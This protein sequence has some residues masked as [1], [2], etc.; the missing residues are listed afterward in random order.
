MT[1]E[2]QPP[3]GHSRAASLRT[4][5]ILGDRYL[6]AGLIGEGGMGQIYQARDRRLARDVAI[7]VLFASSKDDP[8]L[9]RRLEQE[10]RVAGSLNHPNV[11]TV[12][13]VGTHEGTPYVVSELL[14]GTTLR[15]KLTAGL[16]TRTALDFAIQIAR[17][18]A[19]AHDKGI[20]HR[21]VKPE[22]VFVTRDGRVKILDFGLA[23]QVETAPLEDRATASWQEAGTTPGTVLGTMGYMSPEQLRGKPADHR[24]DIFSFGAV[25]YELLSGQRAFQGK[26]AADTMTQILTTEPPEI[27]MT[28]GAPP[29]C[30]AIVRRCLA[31][32]PD[33]RFRSAHDLVFALE[34]LSVPSASDQDA[35]ARTS[36]VRPRRRPTVAAVLPW[37]VAALA[38][39]AAAI[40]LR[41]SP[42]ARTPTPKRFTV[43]L[44]G[45]DR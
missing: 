1:L 8:N 41:R 26:T 4:G 39:V 35:T 28:G 25:L 45:I 43:L 22:N 42:T 23:K 9:L 3:I 27:S 14:E 34:T 17:G 5:A 33:A 36:T 40:A 32:D 13:D 6:I 7:K 19:V 15:E 29:A 24:S 18:L 10:A 12:Y 37:V 16:P 21:D 20:I 11:L 30:M 31:K 44:S 2:R 38:V